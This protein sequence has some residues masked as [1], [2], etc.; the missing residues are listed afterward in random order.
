M[1]LELPTGLLD[2]IAVIARELSAEAIGSL[3]TQIRSLGEVGQGGR[4]NLPTPQGRAL[5]SRLLKDWNGRPNV[6]PAEIAAALIAAGH[7]GRVVSDSQVIELVRTGPDSPSVPV[8]R[9]DEALLEVIE[10]AEKSLLVVSFVVFEIPRVVEAMNRAIS[11]GVETKVILEFE[12]ADGEQSFDPTISLRRLD[13]GCKTFYWPWRDRPSI[14][15]TDKKGYI[16]VKCAVSDCE[17]VLISSANL[18]RYALEANM[19][20]GVMVRGGACAASNLRPLRLA[21]QQSGVD[22][23]SR[24]RSERIA[25]CSRSHLMKSVMSIT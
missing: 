24:C 3:A 5:V 14:P 11:R 12:G 1:T 7:T 6:S 19:E 17:T 18:T 4:L 13:P 8:R 16:H 23:V 25:Q 2:T 21:D 15:E 22:P 20:L 9:I 10:S